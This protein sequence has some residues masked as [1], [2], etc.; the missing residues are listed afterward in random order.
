M[1]KKKKHYYQVVIEKM[2][3]CN[4]SG[5]K[6]RKLGNVRVVRENYFYRYIYFEKLFVIQKA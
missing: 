2:M 6:N 4:D 1:K 3:T 5:V